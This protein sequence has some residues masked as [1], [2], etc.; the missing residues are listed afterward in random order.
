MPFYFISLLYFLILILIILKLNVEVN[1]NFRIFFTNQREEINNN[2][3]VEIS[4]HSD[5]N[6]P[7]LS[8]KVHHSK[9]IT[10]EFIEKLSYFQIS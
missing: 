10:L 3:E 4:I 5:E 2:N 6:K 7:A 1:F 8:K 9:S